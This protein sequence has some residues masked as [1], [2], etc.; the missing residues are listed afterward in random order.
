MFTKSEKKK[1]KTNKMVNKT[2]LAS[3]C[4]IHSCKKPDVGT[5]DGF[6][7]ARNVFVLLGEQLRHRNVF[8]AH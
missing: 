2:R 8:S 6:T 4:S 7:H 1:T 3:Y 5:Y